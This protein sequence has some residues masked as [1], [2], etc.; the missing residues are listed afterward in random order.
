[1]DMELGRTFYLEAPIDSTQTIEIN[2]T[3]LASG[4]FYAVQNRLVLK[5]AVQVPTFPPIFTI[6]YTGGYNP[7]PSDVKSACIL[8]TLS[9][10]SKKNANGISSFRQDLLSVNYSQESL[11]N[12]LG[13]PTNASI[14]RTIVNKY[15]KPFLA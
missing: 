11:E 1:M 10:N 2:N 6:E 15:R 13:D 3:A 14:V 12:V 7:I 9:L 4:E 8:I 5:T